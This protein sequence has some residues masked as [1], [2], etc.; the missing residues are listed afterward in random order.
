MQGKYEKY[1]KYL[2]SKKFATIISTIFVL[3]IAVFVIFSS[4]SKKESFFSSGIKN[5]TAL[6]VENQTI[7]DLIGQDSD[8]DGISD[9]EEALWGTNKNRAQTFADTPDAV[10][11]A[12]KKK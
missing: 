6:K 12:N 10:Y 5:N 8:S 1:L 9:W 2:P 4:F 7:N 11:I 3:G